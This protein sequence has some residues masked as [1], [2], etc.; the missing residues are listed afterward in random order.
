MAPFSMSI[1]RGC[2]SAAGPHVQLADWVRKPVRTLPLRHLLWIGP[3]FEHD[4]TWRIEHACDYDLP[5]CRI[6]AA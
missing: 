2:Y 6:L 5:V 3:R 1:S 4:L